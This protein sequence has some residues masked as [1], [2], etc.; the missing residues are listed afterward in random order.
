MDWKKILLKDFGKL[1]DVLV[2]TQPSVVDV[3]GSVNK[4]ANETQPTTADLKKH[5]V[6]KE[7]RS[8]KNIVILKPDKGNGVVVLDCADY[9]QGLLKIISDTSK[10]RPI[11]E[12]PTLLREGRLQR[13][14][15]K[16]K[17]NGHL[18]SD[19][20]NSIYPRGSQPA[21]IY[22][23]PKMHKER[24]HN[25]IPQFRPTVSS[26]GTYNY[27]LTKYLC[28]LLTPHIP[29]E[30][31]ASDTFTFVQDIQGL[32]MHGKF[33]V[34]FHI[35]SLFTNIPLEECIDLA[36]KYISDGD[37][38]IK[39]SNTKLKS[40]FSAATAQTH[41]LFKGSFYDQIDG[42]AMGSP[43]APVLSYLFMG[44]HEK[45]WHPNIRFTMEKETD[46]KIPFLDVL[47]NIGTHFPVTSVY[48]K[49]T[50]TGP[51]D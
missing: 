16:L 42:V 8:N 43:L 38:D 25:S 20:Y 5:R 26:I 10:F 40:L 27:N 44:N 36:V 46:H 14:L 24:G 19:V 41:F 7:L 23:L 13:L 35:V 33:M 32:S 47:I 39:L 45:L 17:K 30:H 31:C 22:G 34:S 48:H 49:K 50:F 1:R 3:V 18:D 4:H 9:D 51:F 29:T 2:K 21:R 15:R 11:K 12:D 28:N 37:P 6:L